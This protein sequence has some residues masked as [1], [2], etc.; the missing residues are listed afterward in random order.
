MCAMYNAHING[1]VRSY[2]ASAQYLYTYL[3]KGSGR[4]AAEVGTDETQM[5]LAKED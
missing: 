5:Y 1:A 3:Y 2:V 4:A